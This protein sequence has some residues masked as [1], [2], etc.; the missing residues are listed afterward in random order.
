MPVQA[1]I[2][3]LAAFI[4]LLVTAAL[5]HFGV[6][7]ERPARAQPEVHRTRDCGQPTGI[8][9]SSHPDDGNC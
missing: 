9:S 2:E 4:A 8:H 5:S 3:L 6:D 7:V 1:L